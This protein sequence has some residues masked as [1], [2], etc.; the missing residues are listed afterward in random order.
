M[1]VIAPGIELDEVRNVE[2]EKTSGKFKIGVVVDI[3]V[4]TINNF[5]MCHISYIKSCIFLYIN[6]ELHW[7]FLLSY[8]P[9]YVVFL[10]LPLV[11]HLDINCIFGRNILHNS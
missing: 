4:H 5:M 2:R 7:T 11:N 9:L 8:A 1:E 10:H 3:S 6:I